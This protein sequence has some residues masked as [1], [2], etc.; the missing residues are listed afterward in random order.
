MIQ[1]L[2]RIAEL[3]AQHCRSELDLTE[4]FLERAAIREYDGG[5]TRAQAE[6]LALADVKAGLG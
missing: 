5:Y 1:H 6:R 3:A 4:W 2:A